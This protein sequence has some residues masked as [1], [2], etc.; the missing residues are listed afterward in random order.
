MSR[1]PSDA[2]GSSASGVGAGHA[3]GAVARSMAKSGTRHATPGSVR[4]SRAAIARPNPAVW[5]SFL[6]TICFL[7]RGSMGPRSSGKAR[8]GTI[9]NATQRVWKGVIGGGRPAQSATTS[10]NSMSSAAKPPKTSAWRVLARSD[11]PCSN[12]SVNCSRSCRSG[13]TATQHATSRSAATPSSVSALVSGMTA[14]PAPPT[15]APATVVADA[16]PLMIAEADAL[17]LNEPVTRAIFR[18]LSGVLGGGL[19]CAGSRPSQR[20]RREESGLA[21]TATSACARAAT[22][23]GASAEPIMVTSS[24]DSW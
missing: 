2:V 9:S 22:E 17:A 19:T 8:R 10:T 21:A 4:T 23:C 14:A 12:H 13:S 15:D 20:Q 5:S 16:P 6:G 3:E 18:S 11:R 7:S 1:G 24:D